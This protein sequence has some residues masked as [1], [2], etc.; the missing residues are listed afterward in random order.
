MMMRADS[1]LAALVSLASLETDVLDITQFSR[2]R[3]QLRTVDYHILARGYARKEPFLGLYRLH[4]PP[5]MDNIYNTGFW[6]G[7]SEFEEISQDR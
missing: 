7:F 5:L 6:L 3:N 1:S 2:A 4:S